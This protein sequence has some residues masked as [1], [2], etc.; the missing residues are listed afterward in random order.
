MKILGVLV[1]LLAV[2]A[3]LRRR[4]PSRPLTFLMVALSLATMGMALARLY[5][6]YV[7]PPVSEDSVGLRLGRAVAADHRGGGH[8]LLL[9]FPASVNP[10]DPWQE[11]EGRALKK[12]LRGSGLNLV[13]LEERTDL[14]AAWTTVFHGSKMGVDLVSRCLKAHTGV[15]AVVSFVGLPDGSPD[16]LQ[17]PVP[18]FYVFGGDRDASNALWNASG[19]VK[20]LVRP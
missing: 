4:S 2:V 20:L 14:A 15:V 5:R 9:Q 11:E 8:V 10:H 17:Q 7:S 6:H 13:G 16:A 18:P 19:H 3:L 1:V 12:A